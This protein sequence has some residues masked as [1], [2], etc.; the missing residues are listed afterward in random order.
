[1]NVTPISPTAMAVRVEAIQAVEGELMAVADA[2]ATAETPAA[3][4][5]PQPPASTPGKAVDVAR[6]QAAGRQASLAPLFADLAQAMTA[7]VLSAPVRAAIAKVLALQTPLAGPWTAETLKQAVAQSGLFLEAHL[8]AAGR[9]DPPP[10][11]LKAA[12]LTLQQALG[13]VR[14]T[15]H[16]STAA[17]PARDAM[18]E[19]QPAQ[20]ATLPTT[21]DA[22]AIAQHLRGEADQ[23]IARQTLHQLASLPDGPVTAW[24]FELPLATPQGTALAQFEVERDGAAADPAEAWSARFSLDVEP[25]G[26]VHVQLSLNGAGAAVTV[27]AE[28][29]E[30][31]VRLRLEGGELAQALPAKVT[32]RPGAPSRPAPSPGAFV[33]QAS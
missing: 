5:R 4:T 31:L 6:A 23:A 16:A 32:F 1:M 25:L 29:E 17:P 24:M 27:W 30:G 11:D 21:A 33:D 14:P 28:R 22:P 3:E 8:A 26:P 18:L 10:A 20:A 19:G 2:A 13:P 9:R 12:L 15:A 7:P